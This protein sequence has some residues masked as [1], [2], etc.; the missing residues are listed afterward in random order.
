VCYQDGVRIALAAAAGAMALG[1]AGAASGATPTWHGVIDSKDGFRIAVPPKWYFVPRT[2]KQVQAVITEAKKE[3]LN[4]V[5]TAYSFYLTATGKQQLKDFAL[6]AFQ[7]VYPSTDPLIPQ[8]AVQISKA[9]KPGYKASDLTSAAD[10]FGEAL[11][12]N[13]G[14][15]VAKPKTTKLAAGKAEVLVATTPVG[16]GLTEATTLYLLIHGGKLYVLKFDVDAAAYNKTAASVFL[17][18][19]Q[20]FKFS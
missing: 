10:T 15:M 19:A 14:A 8:V 12:Q 11:S 17:A 16:T 3:K 2:V 5:P 7:N 9:A 18:I 6:Q 13:K 20:T 1:L 4:G